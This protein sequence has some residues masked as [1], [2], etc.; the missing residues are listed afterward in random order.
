MKT[1]DYKLILCVWSDAESHDTWME[2]KDVTGDTSLEVA[3]IGWLVADKP[4]RLVL[5]ASMDLSNEKDMVSGHVTIPK[6]MIKEV[7]ELTVK[8]PKKPKKEHVDLDGK[9]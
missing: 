5:V 1:T 7:R 3:S 2:L 8:R 9:I 6:A 4:D